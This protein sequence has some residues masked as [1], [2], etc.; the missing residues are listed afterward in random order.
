MSQMKLK[1]FNYFVGLL[2]IFLYSPLLSEE[3]IDIWKNKKEIVSDSPKQEKKNN[4]GKPNLPSSQ[5][6]QTIEKIQIEES[7]QIQTKEQVV[8]GIYEP[9]NFDFNLNMWSTT[10]AEDLR[11]SL[12]RLNKVNLSK[13]SIEI[14]EA[15]LFSF[16]Y[17]PQGMDEKEFIDLKINWLIE[18]DRINLIESF[19][20]QNEKFD[21]KSKAVQYLV[22]RNIAS[23]NIKEGCEQ[24]KFIDTSIKDSYLEKFKIYC[25]IFN[26]KKS[27]AQLLLDLLREQ[28]QSS[29]FYDDKINFLLGVTNKTNNKINEKN[30][31]NFY[32]SS[33]TI[34]DFKYEPTKKTKP[35]IWK[36][37]NAANLIKLEDASNKEKLKELEIAA[38]ED[39]LNKKKI[40]EIYKQIPFNLNTLINAKNNYQTLNESDA[41]ALIYQK[42]LLSE[43]SESK[44]EYLFLLEEL[45]KK[46]DLTNVY[47]KYLSDKI[48]EIGIEN[49]PEEY[50]EIAKARIVS[51][52]DLILGKVK[53]N[54]KILHQS[55]ILKYY[56]EGESKKKVQKDIDK[57]FKKIS[58]NKKYFVSAKD[59]ALAD[60]LITDGFSLP[61][62]FKYNELVEKFDVPSNLLQLIDNNQ[63]AFLALKIVEIIGE[64]EPYQLDPETIFFVTNLL[65]KM[66]LVTIRNKVLNSALPLR[67]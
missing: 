22:N 42:Y 23:G 65:N 57:I 4:Q 67:T 63:K 30:L 27:E 47:S 24:I 44:I 59:L 8:Y 12:K 16:S 58:K 38:N 25:L 46:A 19:L 32:L 52:E 31:L 33:V 60:A 53:Y 41:R 7:S 45:F 55:K 2:I 35:E 40:F 11:S 49:F 14:L 20:K 48:E 64:D 10:K 28:K 3:K 34:A 13:S 29:K 39:Q 17:P 15:I 66:N 21:S 18:N 26:E 54:D 1:S 37:L 5:T 62:N 56:V 50:Q 36:Y 6:I 61:S 51:E 9:A 43:A